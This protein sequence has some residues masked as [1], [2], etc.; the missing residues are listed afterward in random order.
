MLTA[1]KNKPL[2]LWPCDVTPHC[3][4]LDWRAN[5]ATTPLTFLYSWKTK[6]W[7]LEVQ[8]LWLVVLILARILLQS[9]YFRDTFVHMSMSQ[10]KSSI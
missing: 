2:L 7:G 8:Y 10:V 3:P 9:L 5:D 1:K 6:M 4:L